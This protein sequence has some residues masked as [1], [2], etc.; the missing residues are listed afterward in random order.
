M[1]LKYLKGS[2]VYYTKH[3][4]GDSSLWAD[5]LHVRDIYFC[6]RRMQVGSGTLTSFWD[7]S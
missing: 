6:G 5:M 2:G 1:N 4:P 3:R 7:D